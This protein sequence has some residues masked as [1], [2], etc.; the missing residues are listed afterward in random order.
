MFL[1]SRFY[2]FSPLT[3]SFSVWRDFSRFLPES[4]AVEMLKLM[5]TKWVQDS[6]FNVIV[7]CPSSQCLQSPLCHRRPFT[8]CVMCT[9]KEVFYT[10]FLVDVLRIL[11]MFETAAALIPP[12]NAATKPYKKSNNCQNNIRSRPQSAFPIQYTR[13][14]DVKTS[15]EDQDGRLRGYP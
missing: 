14:I 5:G 9:K 6:N 11:H 13:I 4:A 15:K 3:A 7:Q 1:L 10:N 12:R 2:G 8:S